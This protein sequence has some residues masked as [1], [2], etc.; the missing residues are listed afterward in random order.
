MQGSQHLPRILFPGVRRPDT[1]LSFVGGN[2]IPTPPGIV[3][4]FASNGA[5]PHR[6]F[7]A[8]DV[9]RQVQDVVP[10]NNSPRIPSF[11]NGRSAFE[12]LQM[13]RCLLELNF[14]QTLAHFAC[15][16]GTLSKECLASA[17]ACRPPL[18]DKFW[19]WAS[20]DH[21]PVSGLQ[22]PE[23]TLMDWAFYLWFHPRPSRYSPTSAQL[24]LQAFLFCLAVL[25]RSG[26]SG[27]QHGGSEE[28]FPGWRKG[29]SRRNLTSAGR[30]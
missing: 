13:L 19:R 28:S 11:P 17:L 6:V 18:C 12:L 2:R 8:R 7:V 1:K 25:L 30:M 27:M 16:T 4:R 24:T 20:P 9:L 26:A 21:P 10:R 14:D 23:P 29:C 15:R 3:I 5:S 22:C